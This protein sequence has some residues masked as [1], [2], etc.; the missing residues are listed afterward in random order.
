M[1]PKK[2]ESNTRLLNDR[3]GRGTLSFASQSQCYK[4]TRGDIEIVE[5]EDYLT[6]KNSLL[7]VHC[8]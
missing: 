7:T 4:E 2:G 8:I 1:I 3:F 5:L 6:D